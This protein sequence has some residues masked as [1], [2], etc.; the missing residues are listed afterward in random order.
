[1]HACM[2]ARMYVCTHTRARAQRERE[3]QMQVRTHARTYG[4]TRAHEGE[5]KE[6]IKGEGEDIYEAGRQR[7]RRKDEVRE[8]GEGKESLV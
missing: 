5:K 3:R 4:R 2:H 6:E 7:E 1:M 8:K